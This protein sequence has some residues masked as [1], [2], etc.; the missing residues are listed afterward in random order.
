[1]I[2][3]VLLKNYDTES[4][5]RF[6]NER[7]YRIFSVIKYHISLTFKNRRCRIFSMLNAQRKRRW[8][9]KNRR[10]FCRFWLEKNRDTKDFSRLTTDCLS[11]RENFF[12]PETCYAQIFLNAA[13]PKLVFFCTIIS[14][15]AFNS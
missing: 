4:L 6:Q 10:N 15:N 2:I 8:Q 5:L 9:P 14:Y 13:K 1:M 12:K 7:R 3:L 11:T